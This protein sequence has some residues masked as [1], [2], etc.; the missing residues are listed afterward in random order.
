MVNKKEDTCD[1][2][3]PYTKTL[4]YVMFDKDYNFKTLPRG[5]K[6]YENT[7]EMFINYYD[8]GKRKESNN[9][10]K[11]IKNANKVLLDW[12]CDLPNLKDNKEVN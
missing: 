9:I 1:I 3:M 8:S 12:A 5:F 4:I 10:D 2:L 7:I 11:E 6:K